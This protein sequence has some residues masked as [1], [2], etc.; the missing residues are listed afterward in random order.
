VASAVI[1]VLSWLEPPGGQARVCLPAPHPATRAL[2]AAG[3]RVTEFDL[4]MASEPGLIDPR[5]LV[6]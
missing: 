5:T 1:A 3:W 2:L 6:P 4:H